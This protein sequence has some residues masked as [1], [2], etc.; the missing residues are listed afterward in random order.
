MKKKWWD[1]PIIRV[2][3]LFFSIILIAY[4]IYL[5]VI[6]FWEIKEQFLHAKI[7]FLALSFIFVFIYDLLLAYAWKIVIGKGRTTFKDAFVVLYFSQLGKYLPGKIWSYAAQVA[8][9]QR[10]Q[11]K[12]KE[13]ALLT[14]LF[15]TASIF[16]I[17]TFSGIA[18]GLYRNS[19]QIVVITVVGV[20]TIFFFVFRPYMGEYYDFLWKG[21][22]ALMFAD[23]VG[24]IAFYFLL[25]AVYPVSFKESLAIAMTF[26]VSWFVGWIALFS[27][28]GLGIREG[29]NTYLLHKVLGFS[30]GFASF[31]PLMI[32]VILTIAEATLIFIAFLIGKREGILAFWRKKGE[33]EISSP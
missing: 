6:N 29:V 32:R 20:L 18:V 25:F 2:S 30:L 13:A 26:Y 24:W 1:T 12:P 33:E 8:L 14:F 21:Y 22:L 23:T 31:F 19:S 16:G 9:L 4:V 27:P 15:Y 10:F 7:G 17:I 11:I 28:G 3:F 5:A